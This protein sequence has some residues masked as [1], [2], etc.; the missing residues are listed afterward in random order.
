MIWCRHRNVNKKQ[1][2]DLRCGLRP[3]WLVGAVALPLLQMPRFL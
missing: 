2:E 1:R 3:L